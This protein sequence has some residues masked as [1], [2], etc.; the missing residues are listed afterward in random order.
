METSLLNWGAMAMWA[1]AA[2]CLAWYAVSIASE[3][4]YVTLADVQRQERA[5]GGSFKLLLRVV[6]ILNVI[7]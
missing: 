6:G 2:A 5:V 1:V 4:T 7:V 3:V